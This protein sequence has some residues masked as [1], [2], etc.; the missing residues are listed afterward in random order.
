MPSQLVL[1]SLPTATAYAYIKVF[2]TERKEISIPFNIND[3]AHVE[4]I[5]LIVD[6]SIRGDYIDLNSNN[7]TTPYL[8]KNRNRIVNFGMAIS[9]HNA[10]NSTNAM[11]RMGANPSLLD[12][13]GGN[14]LFENPFIWDYARKSGFKTYYLDCQKDNIYQNFM[15]DKENDS[16]DVYIRYPQKEL[17]PYA[18]HSAAETMR[19]LISEPGRKFIYVNKVG[20][21][22]H[23]NRVFPKEKTIFKPILDTYDDIA[24]N[25]LKLINSY[26]NAV[27]WNVNDFFIKLIEKTDL[28]NT[29]IIYTSD[30]GQ[31]LLDDGL[32]ITHGRIRDAIPQEAIVPMFIIT[33]NAE[34]KK[35][36]QSAAEI[37]FNKTSHFQIFPTLLTLM[38]YNKSDVVKNYYITLFEKNELFHGFFTGNARI[39]RLRFNPVAYILKN[40]SSADVKDNSDLKTDETIRNKKNID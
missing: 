34:L 2:G 20:A 6:E 35:K 17:R 24:S 4:N 26:K 19:K 38:G 13:K 25:R 1:L 5:I 27:R 22:F 29:L 3:L 15:N 18:D 28:S 37:N 16:L 9:G 36:F 40:E 8:L 39:G 10:S 31:N 11:I 7:D 14:V 12:E 21:H 30:H 32:P 33:D 23:Y